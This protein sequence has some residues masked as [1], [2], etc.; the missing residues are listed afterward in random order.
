MFMHAAHLLPLALGLAALAGHAQ[1]GPF[2]TND[3]AY[4]MNVCTDTSFALNM[5]PGVVNDLD[6]TNRGCLFAGEQNGTWFFV[7]MATAGTVWP[8]PYSHCSP[9]TWTSPSG[10]HSLH[11]LRPFQRTRP[12]AASAP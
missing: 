7:R 4:A 8:S 11:H 10:G 2:L 5:G 6:P 1:P 3:A 12:G 9:Q